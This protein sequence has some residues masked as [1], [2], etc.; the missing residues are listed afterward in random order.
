MAARASRSQAL[1]WSSPPTTPLVVLKR[2]MWGG[3]LG[4]MTV[5][6]LRAC[7]KKA[8]ARSD[9]QLPLLKFFKIFEQ[10]ILLFHF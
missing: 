4:H 10:R 5:Q 9:A 3:L 7:A 8:W 2:G 1:S 6:W